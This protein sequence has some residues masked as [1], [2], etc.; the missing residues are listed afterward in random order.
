MSRDELIPWLFGVTLIIVLAVAIYSYFRTR[1]GQ[2]TNSPAVHGVTQA[3]GSIS[4]ER[5]AER[6]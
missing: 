3:D 2:R 6:R 5:R 1:R 4:G